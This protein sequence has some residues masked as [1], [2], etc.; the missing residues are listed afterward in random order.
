MHNYRLKKTKTMYNLP[1]ITT[2]KVAKI[3][4]NNYD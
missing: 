2:S 3:I 4:N 1:D